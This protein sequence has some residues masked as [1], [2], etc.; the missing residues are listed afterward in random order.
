MIQNI[1]GKVDK[2]VDMA[3][4]EADWKIIRMENEQ[5]KIENKKM[6]DEALTPEVRQFLPEMIERMS[7]VRKV[8]FLEK[9]VEEE[10]IKAVKLEEQHQKQ[11]AVLR[12]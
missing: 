9:V 2:A 6:I 11:L 5:M 1:W 8:N 7:E 12:Q 4:Y 10:K 3:R